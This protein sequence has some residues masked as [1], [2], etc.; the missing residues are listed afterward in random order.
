MNLERRTFQIPDDHQRRFQIFFV[1]LKSS[2]A[3]LWMT[4]LSGTS[5]PIRQKIPLDVSSCHLQRAPGLWHSGLWE[6]IRH[7]YRVHIVGQSQRFR[8]YDG[9][10]SSNTASHSCWICIFLRN[11]EP[12]HLDC[13]SCH[14]EQP[15]SNQ[16][17]RKTRQLV[18]QNHDEQVQKQGLIWMA[19]EWGVLQR[20][21]HGARG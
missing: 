7:T 12:T 20:I 5:P 11:F 14:V 15:A 2:S 8:E 1:H 9:P 19:I 16:V 17:P 10:F 13:G 21:D 18:L 4:F 6:T 3:M